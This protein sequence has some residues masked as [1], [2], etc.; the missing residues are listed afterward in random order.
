MMKNENS[1]SNFGS[2]AIQGIQSILAKQPQ[3]PG[4]RRSQIHKGLEAVNIESNIGA[5]G[6]VGTQMNLHCQPQ[7]SSPK[8]VPEKAQ[9]K[10]LAGADAKHL[11][12][13]S[14]D[15]PLRPP[16]SSS[17]APNHPRNH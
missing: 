8:T 5:M 9:Q 2:G 17:E 7:V 4:E 3:K 1:V 6:A 13:S 11:K 16:K 15:S 12:E 14:H 10:P